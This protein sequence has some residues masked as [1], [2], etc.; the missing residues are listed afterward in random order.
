MVDTN[1]KD[2]IHD[3]ATPDLIFQTICDGS[4]A[5]T[6]GS[7]TILVAY[8]EINSLFAF[9]KAGG[10]PIASK[11]LNPLLDLKTEKEMDLEGATL[12]NNKIWWIGS[13]GRDGKGEDAPNRQ[14]LFATNI[15]SPDLSDLE[16]L[17]GPIDLLST[18]LAAE[19]VKPILTPAV[20]ARKPKAGGINIEGLSRHQE[21]G[22]LLGFRSP[23]SGPDGTSGKALV[24]HVL[25]NNNTFKVNHVSQLNLNNRGI[26]DIQWT[27][28][29]YLILAGPVHKGS[30]FGLYRWNGTSEP[31][32]IET[33]VLNGLNAEALVQLNGEWLVISDDGKVERE[34]LESG[35]GIRVCDKIRKKNSNKEQHLNVFFRART[36]DPSLE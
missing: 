12:V 25:K 29:D 10:Q 34:D 19:Q 23:L 15:P 30:A 33:E 26:R 32:E 2:A 7:D 8:D 4:A 9:S 24:V 22:L 13:H 5:V 6:I 27:G 35:D 36:F 3:Q 20:Q 21:A 18:L 1:S 16:I 17:A 14:A 31:T 28:S 11:D